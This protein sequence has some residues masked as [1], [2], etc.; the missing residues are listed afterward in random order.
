MWSVLFQS[1]LFWGTHYPEI[2][3]DKKKPFSLILKIHLHF[4]SCKYL[5]DKALK[6]AFCN[7]IHKNT[8]FRKRRIQPVDNKVNYGTKHCWMWFSKERRMSRPNPKFLT[9]Q[10][11]DASALI[12]S[13]QEKLLGILKHELIK[14]YSGKAGRQW[15]NVRNISKHRRK[16]LKRINAPSESLPSL[17]GVCYLADV[18]VFF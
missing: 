14:L 7:I 17:I 2:L 15:H 6:R 12:Y 10:K 11:L 5:S 3:E 9:E 4:C 18:C 13:G 1:L 16:I 8:C